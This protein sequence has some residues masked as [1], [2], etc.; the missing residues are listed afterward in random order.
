MM[1]I[2]QLTW[3]HQSSES[4]MLCQ[5]MV[6]REVKIGDYIVATD[7]DNQIVA[8]G[9]LYNQLGN[10]CDIELAVDPA[11]RLIGVGR[12]LVKRLISDADER[13]IEILIASADE[14][15]WLRLGFESS[16]GGG[17][18]CLLKASQQALERTWHQG[19]PMTDYMRL[20][21]SRV[22]RNLVETTTALAPN[23]NV[24]QTM[25]AGAIYSQAVL[26][27][28]G[29]AHFAL[30]RSGLVGSIV[31]ADGKMKYRKPISEK[32]RAIINH[33]ITQEQLLPLLDNK[34]VSLELEVKMFCGSQEK[35]VA[36]FTGRYVI[37]PPKKP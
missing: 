26:T 2:D 23:I 34:K 33:N 3:R 37:I 6:S 5:F 14:Q 36:T 30:Q 21:I 28:W 19:I 18:V 32:P 35:S 29:L 1:N 17:F 4:L 15:F 10:R 7:T 9:L 16:L 20:S 13:Q 24:H 22:E 31:L 27:G 8:A 11:Y 25:F 12:E